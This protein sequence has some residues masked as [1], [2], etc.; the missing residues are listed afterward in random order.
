VKINPIIKIKN[1]EKIKTL[2]KTGCVI[3]D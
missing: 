3:L 1:R 2:A